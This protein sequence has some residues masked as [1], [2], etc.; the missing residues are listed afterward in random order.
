MVEK[1]QPASS[2]N[3]SSIST[4]PRVVVLQEEGNRRVRELLAELANVRPWVAGIYLERLDFGG[5]RAVARDGRE[6]RAS[7]SF[8]Q[9]KREDDEETTSKMPAS[10]G[11][12]RRTKEGGGV[13][14]VV[15]GLRRRQKIHDPAE[16]Y[17]MLPS[18]QEEMRQYF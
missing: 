14:S 10:G 7:S 16:E 13:A 9:E 17:L 5:E 11:W 3:R 6:L 12:W 15:E 4:T 2:S 18:E 1:Q 8:N